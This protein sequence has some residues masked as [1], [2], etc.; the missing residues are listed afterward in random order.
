MLL[1]DSRKGVPEV[2]VGVPEINAR[3][4]LPEGALPVISR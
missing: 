4:Q 3:V 1:S 2:A